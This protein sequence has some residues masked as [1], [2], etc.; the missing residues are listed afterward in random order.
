MATTITIEPAEEGTAKVTIGPFTDESGATFTPITITWKLTDRAGN[1]VNSRTA[2][3]VTPAPT[4]AFLLT[5]DDLAIP[6][7]D[8]RRV[9]TLSWTYNSTLGSGLTG[10]G[11]AFFS[12]EQFVG[13]T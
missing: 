13:V 12:I 4:V 9:L 1:V 5:G 10:R 2:V 7:T 3:S 11:Q 6:A 8:S